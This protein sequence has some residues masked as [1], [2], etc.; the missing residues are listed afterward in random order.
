MN[1]EMKKICR[2]LRIIYEMC[3]KLENVYKFLTLAQILATLFI[4]CSC[5]YLV[6]TTPESSKQLAEIVYMVA[7]GFQLILYCWFGNEVTLKADRIPFYIWECDWISADAQFKKSMIF[8]MVRAKRPLYLTA[9]KFVPL[10][11]ST[12]IAIIKAS[13]SAYAV[14]KNTSRSIQIR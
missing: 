14:I 2:H 11:L 8:T 1:G 13:Y 6:S 12:F 7:M 9:G 10:T 4:L 5:L 3:E